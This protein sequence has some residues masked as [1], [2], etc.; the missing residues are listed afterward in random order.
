MAKPPKVKHVDVIMRANALADSGAYATWEE[1][2]T[3]LESEGCKEARNALK[4]RSGPIDR[5]FW[6]RVD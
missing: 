5:G 6:W 3:A 4:D 1:V 2:Q